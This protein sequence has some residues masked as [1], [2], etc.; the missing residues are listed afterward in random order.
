M[1]KKQELWLKAAGWEDATNSWDTSFKRFQKD[2]THIRVNNEDHHVYI[3]GFESFAN[4]NGTV[5]ALNILSGPKTN[6]VP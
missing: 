2:N 6:A 3:N 4:R 1:N 5:Q